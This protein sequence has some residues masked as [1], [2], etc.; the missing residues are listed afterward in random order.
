MPELVIP[1]ADNRS[2]SV[3]AAREDADPFRRLAASASPARV[4]FQRGRRWFA[5]RNPGRP[6]QPAAKALAEADRLAVI[7]RAPGNGAGAAVNTGGDVMGAFNTPGSGSEYTDSRAEDQNCS[8]A[9]RPA[10]H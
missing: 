10:G 3:A 5:V 7:E 2:K 6:D 4:P 8:L 9:A 1:Q